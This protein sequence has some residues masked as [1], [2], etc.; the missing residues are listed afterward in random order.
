[1]SDSIEKSNFTDFHLACLSGFHEIV[2]EYLEE[3]DQDANCPVPA[4]GD[5]PLHLAL[6]ENKDRR[7][8]RLYMIQEVDENNLDIQIKTC[9][10]IRDVQWVPVDQINWNNKVIAHL[11]SYLCN[12]CP[13][14]VYA[15][16][17]C[18]RAGVSQ[19]EC[20]QTRHECRLRRHKARVT[21][22]PA[23][24][25]CFAHTVRKKLGTCCI[26]NLK[27]AEHQNLLTITEIEKDQNSH[28]MNTTPMI[29]IKK[30]FNNDTESPFQMESPIEISENAEHQQLQTVAE[31]EKED[32]NSHLMT[33]LSGFHEIVKEYLEEYDQDANC[34]VPATGDSPLHLALRENKVKVVEVLL[35][36]GA[37]PISANK[38]GLTPLHIMC[39]KEFNK[40]L[41]KI[42]FKA[43]DDKRQTVDVQDQFHNT[44]LLLA[45]A[46]S[47]KNMAKLLPRRGANPDSAKKKH[48]TPM[49]IICKNYKN[50]G[51]TEVVKTRNTL[52]FKKNLKKLF[53]FLKISF[54]T[55]GKE[56]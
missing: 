44:P 18:T 10:E 3:Y 6:R 1:M 8:T 26:Q 37:N 12:K 53:K 28:L 43:I 23:R 17:V 38:Y 20:K 52:I 21:A 36:N 27:R 25:T 56:K 55:E 46:Y 34:P 11:K 39:Q 45:F 42:F 24:R 7:Y 4:T 2:K 16:N 35:K 31:I 32:Q 9:E 48:I 15:H 51:L 22:M 30:Q 54:G 49:D 47:N 19:Y 41:A 40:D 50:N 13:K 33:C 29:S 5:S 14:C